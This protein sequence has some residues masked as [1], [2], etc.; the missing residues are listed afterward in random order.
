MFDK[1]IYTQRRNTLHKT[2]KTGLALFLGNEESP[3][4]YA[5]NTYHFRQDSSFL[6]FFGLNYPG[7]V[8]IMDFDEQ[9]DYIFGNDYTIDD[10]VWMGIQPTVK[11]KAA[12][13]GIEN[14]APIEALSKFLIGAKQQGRQ[15]HFLPPYRPENKL[16][17]FQWL[18]IDPHKSGQAASVDLI[19][20]VV[21]QRNFKSAA[22]IQ[23]IEQA[24]N[25]SAD[26]HIAAMRLVRPGMTEAEV[27]AEVHRIA[28]AADGDISFPIIATINGQTLHNHFH[29]N[30]LKSGDLFLLDAGAQTAMGYAG[31]LSTTVPVD[32]TFTARQRDIYTIAWDAHCKAVSMLKPGI[33]NKDIHLAAC[34]VIAEG[35]KELGLMKGNL[36]DAVSC[37]AHA[38]FFP[39]GLGHMMGLDVHDMEDLGEIY[40]GYDHEVKS[41][42][43]GLKS[44]RLGRALQ[45]GFV[46][47]IEP[48]IYF[49]P[50]LIDLW[51]K[52]N[53]NT[54][55]LNFDKI[56]EY[57]GFG[58]LRNEEDYLIT[59]SGARRLGKDVPRTIAHVESERQQAF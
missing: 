28:L 40:V 38:L 53:R 8:G 39:C 13:A 56:N 17:L 23:E 51:K 15:I 57:R 47:T 19:Q 36:D 50:D 34:Q 33:K 10:I 20:A 42:Q 48:G 16:K 45:P 18:G 24:V 7:L 43:F 4:N 5:D 46:L 3:M 25:I 55:F 26:M 9:R 54:E 31:D 35:M 11:E 44:L 30:I 1:Q 32:K 52:D 49:I 2:L 12:S 6:Y 21:A 22:E 29:G 37:G 27:A 59:E 58:G 14:S 41:T